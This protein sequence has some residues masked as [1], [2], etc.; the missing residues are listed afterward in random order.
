M[1]RREGPTRDRP[2]GWLVPHGVRDRRRVARRVVAAPLEAVERQR[3]MAIIRDEA[4]HGYYIGYKFQKGLGIF[5]K[6]SFIAP[7]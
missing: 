1:L 7:K 4:V 3:F 6:A 5:H 2:G